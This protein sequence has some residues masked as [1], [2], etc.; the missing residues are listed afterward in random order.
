MMNARRQRRRPCAAIVGIGLLVGACAPSETTVTAYVE[1]RADLLTAADESSISSWHAALL[2]QYDIDYR[3]LTVESADDLSAL[4]VRSFEAGQVGRR[5][6]TGRGLMLVVD[7]AG[8]RLRLEVSRELEGAFVDS[9][10]AFVEREQMAPFF[11][12]GRAGDG[13]VA[14]SELI[15]ARAEAAIEGGE[16]V[17]RA[18]DA[19]SAGAGAESQA[20][21][22]G[23]YER[24][25]ARTVVD[26][27]ARSAPLE[28]VAAY[29]A[30]MAAHHASADLDLYTAETRQMLAGHV[31]TKAQMDN[32]VRTYRACPP[33]RVRI[34]G[35]V[36]VADH[37]GESGGCSPWL[38]RL[39]ADARW[40]LDLVTMQRALR[41]DTHNRW[42]VAVPEALGDFAFAFE[43]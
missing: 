5:S 23:G 3:V 2:D 39:G 6:R 11:A 40:R 41:F 4:A 37:P 28:T 14:T 24:P 32:L 35:D 31:V 27:H 36:A 29:V 20:K 15:A 10:V 18:V 13:I 34:E 22:G 42:H 8:E 16:L 25:Q 9:F 38:L 21:A 30:A 7:A 43:R 17:G 1:D 12:A 33:P 19:S 26:T